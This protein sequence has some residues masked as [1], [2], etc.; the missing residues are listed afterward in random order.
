MFD[1]QGKTFLVF[2]FL[3][4][5]LLTGVVSAGYVLVDEDQYNA[6]LERI[7]NSGN[8]MTGFTSLPPLPPKKVLDQACASFNECSSNYCEF[9]TITGSSQKLCRQALL[10]NGASC[11]WRTD[12]L[13]GFCASTNKCAP[14][15]SIIPSK[16]VNE[17]CVLDNHCD[18]GLIS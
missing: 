3:T 17:E 2:S 14:R 10:S 12:C 4:L 15:P 8:R 1:K 6:L 5:V 18:S 9:P 16:K 7:S 11:V 13:S